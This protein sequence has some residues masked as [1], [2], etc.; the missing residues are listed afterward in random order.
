MCLRPLTEASD[1][2]AVARLV[3]SARAMNAEPVSEDKLGQHATAAGPAATT[4][5]PSFVFTKAYLGQ[6]DVALD[7]LGTVS[8]PADNLPPAAAGPSDGSAMVTF[9][10]PES[11]TQSVVQKLRAG[12]PLSVEVSN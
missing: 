11:Y 6:I 10:I 5:K 7:T 3:N 2:D 12:K 8:P 9:A 4:P 1:A